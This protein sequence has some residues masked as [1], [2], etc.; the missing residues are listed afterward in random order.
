MTSCA[1]GAPAEQVR[2]NLAGLLALH[3]FNC[4]SNI[5]LIKG[6]AQE[7]NSGVE[8]IKKTKLSFLMYSVSFISEKCQIIILFSK[9]DDY[10]AIT[11]TDSNT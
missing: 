1:G 7:I 3:H 4:G 2:G 6:W 10:K 5:S 11:I 8:H 9:K